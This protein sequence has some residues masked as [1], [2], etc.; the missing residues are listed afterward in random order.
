MFWRFSQAKSPRNIEK[1]PDALQKRVNPLFV[2]LKHWEN[3]RNIV[4]TLET[5]FGK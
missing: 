5:L 2:A 3:A 1:T 4:G